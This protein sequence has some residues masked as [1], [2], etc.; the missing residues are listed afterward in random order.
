MLQDALNNQ[1]EVQGYDFDDLEET[2][3]CEDVS[4]NSV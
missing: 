4:Y 3:E 1:I 2:E